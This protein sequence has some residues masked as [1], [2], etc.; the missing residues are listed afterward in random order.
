M[1]LSLIL[2]T[3]LVAAGYSFELNTPFK[4]SFTLSLGYWVKD[5]IFIRTYAVNELEIC[6]DLVEA[7]T[8][9]LAGVSSE[10]WKTVNASNDPLCGKCIK[11]EYE[12]K[13]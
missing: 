10:W 3:A 13:T 7:D 8:T 11:V 12:G 9:M 4:G 2:V 1:N 6:G 5:G